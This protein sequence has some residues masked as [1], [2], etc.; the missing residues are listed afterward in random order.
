VRE[1]HLK[2]I[3]IMYLVSKYK[4]GQTNQLNYKKV[5]SEMGLMQGESVVK[6]SVHFVKMG[7]VLND[8][9][10]QLRENRLNTVQFMQELNKAADQRTGEVLEQQFSN[11]LV[12]LKVQISNDE[13]DAIAT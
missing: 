4:N 9:S 3:D 6:R 7:D 8:L 5:E 1:C 10:C 13:I 11:T 12:R 2:Q